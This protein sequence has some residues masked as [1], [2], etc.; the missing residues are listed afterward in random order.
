MIEP[1][2]TIKCWKCGGSLAVT[3][4]IIQGPRK[5]YGQCAACNALANAQANRSRARAWA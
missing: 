3:D 1:T 5:P 2:K 4:K